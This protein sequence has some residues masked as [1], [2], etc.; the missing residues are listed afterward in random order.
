MGVCENFVFTILNYSE[1]LVIQTGKWYFLIFYINREIRMM[2]E[3]FL[4]LLF[5]WWRDFFRFVIGNVWILKCQ[6][7]SIFNIFFLHE[8]IWNW[9]KSLCHSDVKTPIRIIWMSVFFLKLLNL[10]QGAACL[11]LKDILVTERCVLMSVTYSSPR[12]SGSLWIGARSNCTRYKQKPGSNFCNGNYFFQCCET[13][14]Y[15][16]RHVENCSTGINFA[17]KLRIPFWTIS[18]NMELY[19]NWK[20]L[21]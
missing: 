19:W 7:F 8:I 16:I 2:E 5:E 1:K 21:L 11:W 15:I 18:L 12:K 3:T 14:I 20:D 9:K 10:L 6:K 17:R 4:D 13:C